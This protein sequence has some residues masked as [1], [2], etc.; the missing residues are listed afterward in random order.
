[1]NTPMT[2]MHGQLSSLIVDKL[3]MGYIALMEL[4]LI[5]VVYG[6]C[7]NSH[8]EL[9]YCLFIIKGSCV[10]SVH[11]TLA[12]Y[13]GKIG[14]AY[15]LS[16]LRWFFKCLYGGIP[17]FGGK[18]KHAV[19][20]ERKKR[21]GIHILQKFLFSYLG[22]REGTNTDVSG[23]G[24]RTGSEETSW[25][26]EVHGYFQRN[27]QFNDLNKLA[28]FLYLTDSSFRHVAQIEKV[29]SHPLKRG[30]LM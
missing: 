22:D 12:Y 3:L 4:I 23:S 29:C 1:M 21:V 20:M 16:I 28:L 6:M 5:E 19:L 14:W 13:H 2:G 11:H 10:T 9:T 30:S 17:V 25:L 27:T 26:F 7:L 15:R 24:G 18:L 8:M